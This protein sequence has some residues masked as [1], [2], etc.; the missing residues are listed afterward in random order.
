VRRNYRGGPYADFIR[1]LTPKERIDVAIPR[2]ML[3]NKLNK[4]AVRSKVRVRVTDELSQT[5]Q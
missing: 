4:P 2:G 1:E 3:I 5:V